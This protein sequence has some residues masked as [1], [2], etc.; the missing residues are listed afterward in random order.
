MGGDLNGVVTA[1]ALSRATLGNIKQNLI[2][3]FGYNT[4][5]IPLA[6]GLL[7]ALTGHGLLSPMLASAAMALS[8]VSVVTNALRLRGFKPPT[9]AAPTGRTGF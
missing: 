4:L 1:I 5:G 2:F 8:S 6:A 7:Y 3:A 9:P